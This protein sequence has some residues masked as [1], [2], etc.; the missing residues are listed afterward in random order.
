MSQTL[1]PNPASLQMNVTNGAVPSNG[2]VY[3]F[4]VTLASG[5]TYQ[6]DLRSIQYQNV[7]KDVQGIYVD[8]SQNSTACAIQTSTGQNV[9]IPPYAQAEMSFYLSP[10]T[11]VFTMSGNGTVNCVLLNFKASNIVW[12]V[13]GSAPVVSNKLQVQDVLSENYLSGIAYQQNTPIQPAAFATTAA[14]T[15]IVAVAAAHVVHGGFIKNPNAATEQLY[16]D[17]VNTAQI[18][19][20][21]TSGTCV[22]LSAGQSI[23]IPPGLQNAVTVNAVTSGHQFVVVTY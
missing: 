18:A 5:N 4:N 12:S 1:N 17:F 22:A 9:T 6:I 16:V 11:P 3:A 20:P 21:G 2:R 13:S 7:L 10:S 19:E 8:N 23:A 15:A 14:S